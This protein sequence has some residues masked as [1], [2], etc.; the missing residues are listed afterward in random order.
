MEVAD[1]I[2]NN[3][4]LNVVI[5]YKH[6]LVNILKSDVLQLNLGLGL[7]FYWTNAYYIM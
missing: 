1:G 7:A 2:H 3:C 6:Y 4:V 5:R